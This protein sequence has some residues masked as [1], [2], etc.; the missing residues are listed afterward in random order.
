MIA[1]L[2][3]K[4]LGLLYMCVKKD[5]LMHKFLLQEEFH[6]VEPDSLED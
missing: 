1:F 5:G 3:K 6:V 2:K 4:R